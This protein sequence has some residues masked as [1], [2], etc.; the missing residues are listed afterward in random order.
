MRIA[1]TLLLCIMTLASWATTLTFPERACVRAEQFTVAE[2]AKVEAES[3]AQAAQLNAVVLGASPIIGQ[4]RD[5]TAG[6]IRMRLRQYNIDPDS[7]T[8]ACPPVVTITRLANRL[9]GETLLAVAQDWLRLQ[10]QAGNDELTLTPLRTPDG[11]TLPEGTVR[12]ECAQTGTPSGGLCHVQVS[13]LVNDA[14]AWRG[15]ISFRLQRFG[16]VLVV[17]RAQR[18]GEAISADAV[19]IERR[20]LTNLRGTPLRAVE[21]AVGQ[22]AL[23]AVAVGDILIETAVERMPLV[24]RNAQVN[25]RA[26]CGGLAVSLRAIA[27]E[28][29]SAGSVITVRNTDTQRTFTARVLA[30][31]ELELVR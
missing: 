13:V 8:L 10:L 29:G 22:R 16:E 28:D 15:I 27:C 11:L 30:N 3:E 7:V 23:T 18:K 21:G 9:E 20:D 31:G 4:Q 24:Q 25:V 19:A 1:I 6:M 14:P 12:W 17:K 2:V 26:F 5:L